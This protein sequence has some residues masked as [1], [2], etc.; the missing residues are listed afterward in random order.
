MEDE[1]MKR[2]HESLKIKKNEL[3]KANQALK[4]KWYSL[5]FILMNYKCKTIIVIAQS[6]VEI[7]K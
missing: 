6:I 4:G 1:M 2:M 3:K 7:F 5:I